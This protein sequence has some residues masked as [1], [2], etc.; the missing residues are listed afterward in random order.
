MQAKRNGSGRPKGA[1]HLKQ[2][3]RDADGKTI[4]AA[5]RILRTR[6][7]QGSRIRSLVPFLGPAFI[8]S[9][10]YVDP[11]NF[12]TNIQGGAQFGYTLLWVIV[13]SNL[14][15]MLIQTLSAKLGIATGKNLAESCREHFPRLVVYLM[16]G[17]IELVAMA[18]DLAEFLGSAVSRPNFLPERQESAMR[19]SLC[20]RPTA[21]PDWM[22][23]GPVASLRKFS[24]NPAFLCCSFRPEVWHRPEMPWHDSLSDPT[25]LAGRRSGRPRPDRGQGVVVLF[26]KELLGSQPNCLN[27]I[28]HFYGGEGTGSRSRR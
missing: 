28:L 6:E 16:W 19:I 9:V 3:L 21:K 25:P 15:A 26:L 4:A 8:A 13:A 23:S 10:A 17:I 24:E 20:S 11:G 12:A 2:A 14:M 1:I 22:P 7:T 27:R 18:T 5:Q